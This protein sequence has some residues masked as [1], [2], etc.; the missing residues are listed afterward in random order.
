MKE[1]KKQK[2][3]QLKKKNLKGD[4]LMICGKSKKSVAILQRFLLFIQ[5]NNS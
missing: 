1:A 3:D 4:S 5:S 2:R